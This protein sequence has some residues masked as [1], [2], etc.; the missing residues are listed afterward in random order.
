MMIRHH[1]I[2]KMRYCNK[3]ARDFFTRHNLDWSEF[4]RNGLPEEVILATGD[5]MAIAVVEFARRE[6]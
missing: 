2:R 3:G 5:A 6:G 4:V 1:H